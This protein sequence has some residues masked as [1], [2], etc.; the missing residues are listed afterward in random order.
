[1]SSFPYFVHGD[2]SRNLDLGCPLLPEQVLTMLL[3]EPIVALKF[4]AQSGVAVLFSPVADR[5]VVA[6][7]M[8][9]W[10]QA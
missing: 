2:H 4:A 9:L 5:L 10:A 3:G 6:P 7:A 1:M 8:R